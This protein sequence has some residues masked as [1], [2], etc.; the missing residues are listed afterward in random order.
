[1]YAYCGNNPVNYVD[2]SGCKKISVWESFCFFANAPGLVIIAEIVSLF[3]S[4]SEEEHYA[5]NENNIEFPAVYDKELFPSTEW[6]NDVSANCHQFSSPD[7]TNKKYVSEDGKYEVIYN[8][9]GERVDDPRDIGTYNFASPDTDPIG[10]FFKDVYPW[11]KYGNSEND[12]T[13]ATERFFSFFGIY[14]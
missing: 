10:H 14:F 5:R 8:S 12:T 11:I 13:S 2:Y 9:K 7:R 6:N 4:P 3:V 1:M